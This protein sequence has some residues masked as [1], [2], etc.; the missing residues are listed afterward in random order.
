MENNYEYSA[1]SAE[2]NGSIIRG[3]IGA[4]LG[5]LVGAV[6][7]CGFTI[8]A[9][10]VWAMVG[11]VVGLI[12]GFGYDLFKGRKGTI[13]MV[14]V[15]I[16]VILSVV[17]GTIGTYAW[18]MHDWYVDETDFIATASKQEL[19]EAYMTEEELAEFNS[20][21]AV[22]QQRVLEAFEVT[23]VSEQEYFQLML[24]DK[25]LIKDIGSECL[26]SIFFALLGSF[27]LIRNNG[28]K[29][30]KEEQTVNFDEAAQEQPDSVTEERLSDGMPDAS[31]QADA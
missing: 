21:P 13:R 10:A 8:I 1:E 15:L 20:Y 30:S 22:L 27:T 18:W 9:E 25:E 7:W 17:L 23:M 12:V 3:L 31:E 19:V 26:T 5:A 4:I 24:Q 2:Q 14:V 11:F 16:C 6:L 29:S 28:R